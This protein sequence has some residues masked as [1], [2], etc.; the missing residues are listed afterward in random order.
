MRT[1]KNN[2]LLILIVIMVSAFKPAGRTDFSGT[3]VINMA[4]SN[5]GDAPAY[6]AA[7]QIKAIQTASDIQ[8]ENTIINDDKDSTA[9][10]TIPFTEKGLTLTDGG[11][12]Q[13]V[14]TA[15]WLSGNEVLNII[16]SGRFADDPER[17][18]YR[19]SE[20]WSLSEQGKILTISKKVTAYSGFEYAITAVYDKK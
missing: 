17:E 10:T 16:S 3:W 19:S 12:H 2:S 15:D 14:I 18:E 20:R 11:G 5:F 7:K 8:L 9:R 13:R 4:K 6:T 1:I